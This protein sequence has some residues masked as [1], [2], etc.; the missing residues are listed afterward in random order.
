MR[1]R[2]SEVRPVFLLLNLK[3]TSLTC[4]PPTSFSPPMFA[5]PESPTP[6]RLWE[7]DSSHQSG[8]SVPARKN[9]GLPTLWTLPATSKIA[10]ID[11]SSLPLPH[12][13]TYLLGL[14]MPSWSFQ[15]LWAW[16]TFIGACPVLPRLYAHLDLTSFWANSLYLKIP[17]LKWALDSLLTAEK[18]QPQP[19]S[20]TLFPYMNPLLQANWSTNG[21]LNEPCHAHPQ[22][23]FPKVPSCKTQFKA[24]LSKS[25][26]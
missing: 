10:T 23:C 15:H 24:L 14:V 16:P 7:K 17:L 21:T 9:L 22:F 6:R 12:S 4:R 25:L 26:L 19:T 18:I 1:R 2:K 11:C 5:T 8:F 20:P 3:Y 13:A